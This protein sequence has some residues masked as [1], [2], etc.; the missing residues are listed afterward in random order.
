MTRH[1]KPSSFPFWSSPRHDR[2]TPL[3]VHGPHDIQDTTGTNRPDPHQ[4]KRPRQALPCNKPS[5]TSTSNIH[6]CLL[7]SPVFVI[8]SPTSRRKVSVRRDLKCKFLGPL[9]VVVPNRAKKCSDGA[10]QHSYSMR[11][12]T[13][14]KSKVVCHSFS[15][16]PLLR[17]VGRL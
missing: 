9:I 4:L 10:P 12:R 2:P 6:V 13:I 5:R 17:A 11:P 8:K 15:C 3:I 1:P 14:P 7:C 16:I